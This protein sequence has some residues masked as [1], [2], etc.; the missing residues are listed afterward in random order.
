MVRSREA[1]LLCLAAAAFFFLPSSTLAEPLEGRIEESGVEPVSGSQAVKKTIEPLPVPVVRPRP[2]KLQ[3]QAAQGDQSKLHGNVNQDG[4]TGGVDDE[5]DMDMRPGKATLDRGGV[6]KGGAQKEG[7]NGFE[8][9]DPD[10]DDQEL[11]VEW[12]RWRNRLL[13]AIQSGMQEVINDPNESNLRWDERRQM[14]V[15]KF[16]L[17]TIAWFFCQVTPD[18]RILNAKITKP[19]GYPNYDRA[20]MESIHNLEGSSILRYPRG[21]KRTIVSQDGGI[22]TAETSERRYFKF[23]DVERQRSSAR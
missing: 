13:S 11:Q 8:S 19:S 16:P 4:L 20:I 23:G 2:A 12:D 22:K 21:S 10:A 3:G 18:R 1:R 15:P 9:M 17:G 5:G 7:I 14:M 6:L